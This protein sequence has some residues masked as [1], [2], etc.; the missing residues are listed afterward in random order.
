MADPP[1][2]PPGSS[3]PSPPRSSPP[4]APPFWRRPAFWAT[5]AALLVANW[6]LGSLFLAPS[7]RLQVPYTE[8]QSQ[9][10]AGNVESVTSEGETIQGEFHKSV[11]YPKGS[12][13]R[14]TLF[15][16]NG[17]RTQRTICS[18]RSRPST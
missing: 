17:R 10:T 6:L 9:L 3:P 8:F 16:P 12:A 1:P 2:P 18:R 14:S 5:V 4:S 7:S 15:Q 13:D 11:T